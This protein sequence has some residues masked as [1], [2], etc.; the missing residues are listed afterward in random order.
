M[1]RANDNGA[2]PRDTLQ[3]F[4]YKFVVKCFEKGN[5]S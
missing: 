1:N 5:E 2:E 3:L 4:G